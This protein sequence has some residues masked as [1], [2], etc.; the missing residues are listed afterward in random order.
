M[1][2][3]ITPAKEPERYYSGVRCV[4]WRHEPYGHTLQGFVDLVWSGLVFHDVSVHARWNPGSGGWFDVWTAFPVRSRGKNGK[5]I[6]MIHFERQELYDAW[7]E[8]AVA[9]VLAVPEIDRVIQ[10]LAPAREK[11][12]G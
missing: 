11:L 7:Q 2:A 1:Q 3:A 9:V 8:I 12:H 5:P 6:R 10:A 4:A